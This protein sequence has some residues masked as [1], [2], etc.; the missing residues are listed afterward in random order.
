MT[1]AKIFVFIDKQEEHEDYEI[2][3]DKG[4]VYDYYF[5]KIIIYWDENFIQVVWVMD[6]NLF[7]KA[8]DVKHVIFVVVIVKKV[9]DLSIIFM[10]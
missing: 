1:E 8:N 3:L 4:V 6:K 9:V 10:D 5:L 7:K 2:V